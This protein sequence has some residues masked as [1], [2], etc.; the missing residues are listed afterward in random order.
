MYTFCVL[1][2]SIFGNHHDQAVPYRYASAPAYSYA[3]S[4]A[5]VVWTYPAPQLDTWGRMYEAAARRIRVPQQRQAYSYAQPT[6]PGT[7]DVTAGAARP[8]CTKDRCSYR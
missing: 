7:M 1:F 2:S 4:S 5:E 6:K 8:E 3:R